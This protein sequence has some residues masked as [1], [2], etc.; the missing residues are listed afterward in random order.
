M[1]HQ[2][3]EGTT[4]AEYAVGTIGACTLALVLH[5]LVADGYWF[6][7]V[8]EIFVRALR[9]HNFLDG[10]PIPRIGLR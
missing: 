7:R 6:E 10:V 2:D 3:D 4:T 5:E 9:W 8:T 1:T